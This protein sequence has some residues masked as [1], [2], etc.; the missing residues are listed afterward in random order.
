M[1]G[2][3]YRMAAAPL[4]HKTIE[5]LAVQGHKTTSTIPAGKVGN[6]QPIT[7]TSEE[8]SSPELKVLVLTRHADP[9]LGESSYRLTNIVRAEPDHSLFMVPSDYT[10][11]ETG[12]RRT[13]EAKRQQ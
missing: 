6:E 3:A 7:I 9:R 2:E 12:I 13:A 5:G 4:E 10:L 11:K 1:R 8:W